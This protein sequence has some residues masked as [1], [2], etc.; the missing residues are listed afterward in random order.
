MRQGSDLQDRV[1]LVTGASSGIGRA[2][3]IALA[4]AGA[5]VVVNHRAGGDSQARA[6]AVV[7]AVQRLGGQAVAAAADI[8]REAEVEHLFEQAVRHYGRVDILVNNAGIE[9]PAPVAD[10]TLADWKRVIDVNLTGHF[11][12]ARAAARAYESQPA[13]PARKGLS[14][15]NILFIS[16]VHELIPWAFQVN[17]AA[18]KGGLSMLMKSLAQELA[19]ARIRVNSI[20]PGAIRTAINRPAWDSPESLARLLKL[21]PYGRIGEPE[22]VAR[23]AVWLAGDASDYV[24]GTTLFVDGGM[25]LYPEFRGAG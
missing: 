16:S 3:A 9:H 17:Y 10:M 15:G 4:Q 20:A 23:A 7:E 21:I 13:D 1:A 22:D 2:T 11:L 25:T 19:P 18:S 12:C 24:T 14:R 6:A 8:S 5:R